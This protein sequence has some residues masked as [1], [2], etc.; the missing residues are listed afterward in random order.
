MSPRNVPPDMRAPSEP[1]PHFEYNAS[2]YA[3]LKTSANQFP[4]AVY[5]EEHTSHPGHLR[6]FTYLSGAQELRS[7]IQ[8]HLRDACRRF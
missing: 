7:Q 8:F 4:A 5:M 1:V 6:E 2:S 3:C